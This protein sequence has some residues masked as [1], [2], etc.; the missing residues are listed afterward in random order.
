MENYISSQLALFLLSGL[1]GALGAFVYDLIRAVR[2]RTG[3]GVHLCDALYCVLAA[4]SGAAFTMSAGGVLRLYMIVGMLCGFAL[5]FLTA[6]AQMRQI[7]DFW[8]LAGAKSARI[9]AAPAVFLSKRLKNVIERAKKLFYF[10]RKWF[11]IFYY[12]WEFVLIRRQRK[13][14]TAFAYGKRHKGKENKKSR[15]SHK[16]SPRR[17]SGLRGHIPVHHSKSDTVR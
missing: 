6:S 3:A 14:G 11:R 7:L 16:G 17:A 9:L 10:R 15:I 2:L 4:V 8:T 5:Y 1:L 13:G 12:K